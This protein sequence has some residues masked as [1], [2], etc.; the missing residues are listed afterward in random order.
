MLSAAGAPPDTIPY[1]RVT[2]ESVE[3][4]PGAVLLGEVADRIPLQIWMLADAETYSYA[5]AAHAS[6]LGRSAASLRSA[7]IVEVWGISPRTDQMI[8]QHRRLLASRESTRT[9]EWTETPGGGLHLLSVTRSA[10]CLTEG[11]TTLLCTALDITAGHRTEQRLSAGEYLHRAVM[12]MSREGILVLRGDRPGFVNDSLCS[13]LGE[14]REA[15]LSMTVDHLVHPGDRREVETR[16]HGRCAGLITPVVCRARLLTA[17]GDAVPCEL[18]F[19]R[20]VFEGEAAVLAV[21]TAVVGGTGNA[22]SSHPHVRGE[23]PGSAAWQLG[24]RIRGIAHDLNNMLT[25]VIGNVE[26]AFSLC[27]PAATRNLQAALAACS[28]GAELT[29]QLSQSVSGAVGGDPAPLGRGTASSPLR[30]LLVA[31]DEM[32]RSV[33]T[34]ILE[35]I[36]C[37]VETAESASTGIGVCARSE[38][39]SDAFDAVIVEAMPGGSEVGD[40]ARLFRERWPEIG[41]VLCTGDGIRYA[42]SPEDRGPTVLLEKPYAPDKVRIAVLQVLEG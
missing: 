27:G 9:E 14:S 32:S 21:I 4:V 5:N 1:R 15:I 12:E 18:S 38:G 10:V 29:L 11:A 13:L 28:R 3:S 20:V 8:A 16:M 24:E 17:N 36:G 40:A 41:L 2:G 7:R 42:P 35:S 30:V 31:D 39:T 26:M 6:F 37:A 25:A 19:R 34:E 22:P 23:A 33:L